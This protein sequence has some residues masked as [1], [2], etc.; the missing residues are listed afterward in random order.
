MED[1]YSNLTK[2][3]FNKNATSYKD[4]MIE[5]PGIKF[6]AHGDTE[7]TRGSKESFCALDAVMDVSSL[8]RRI[9]KTSMKKKMIETLMYM[10]YEPGLTL[11]AIPY[12][13]L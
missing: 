11:Q 7:K 4:I 10:G 2:T 12:N 1:C 3:L 13:T 6:R 5:R 9:S 8:N